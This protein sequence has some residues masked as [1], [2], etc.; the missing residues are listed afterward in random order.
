MIYERPV[1]ITKNS[2]IEKDTLLSPE[3]HTSC[4]CNFFTSVEF[5]WTPEFNTKF[6]LWV[7]ANCEGR[8][9]AF[10]DFSWIGFTHYSDAFEFMLTF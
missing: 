6:W 9:I 2:E 4:K 10:N 8:V 5:E 3:Y 1:F 7:E